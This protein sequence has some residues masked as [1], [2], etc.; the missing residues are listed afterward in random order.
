MFR[1]SFDSFPVKGRRQLDPD[2]WQILPVISLP[3]LVGVVF[4]SVL[5]LF[6]GLPQELLSS[7]GLAQISEV[8]KT[9]LQSFLHSARFAFAALILST[10]ILGVFLIPILSALRGF[11]FSCCVATMIQP[12][13]F[14]KYFNVFLSLGIPA[15]M[16]FSGFLLAAT[17]GFRLSYSFL[18]HQVIIRDKA[19]CYLRHI[20]IIFVLCF[21]NA[22]YIRFLAPIFA[23]RFV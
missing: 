21:V 16:E 1:F 15:M 23:E 19:L 6:S 14:L 20:L 18:S 3:F 8:S 4:G 10:G 17:D 2:G 12:A 13:A 5:G 9:F 22:A 11:A 7:V